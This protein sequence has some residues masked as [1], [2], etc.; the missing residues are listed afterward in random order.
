METKKYIASRGS[1]GNVL[2]PAEIHL[3][4]NEIMVKFPGFFSGK[5]RNI[6]Y[7]QI[8]GVNIETPL[9]GFSTITFVVGGEKLTG[10][11]FK[12]SEVQEIKQIC[13]A[14]IAGASQRNQPGTNGAGHTHSG[15]SVADELRKLKELLD[16]GI[17]NQQ[18][19]D[20]QKAKILNS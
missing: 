15:H 18:E 10:H 5:S 17:I 12:K 8:E 19:F 7:H 9:I 14:K 6:F 11:G 20:T 4:D 1:S 13:S 3:E 16:G 2:F